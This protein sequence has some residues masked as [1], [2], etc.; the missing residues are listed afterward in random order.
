MRN[1]TGLRGKIVSGTRRVL[2]FLLA[3][4]LL[5]GT[6]GSYKLVGGSEAREIFLDGIGENAPENAEAKEAVRHALRIRLSLAESLISDPAYADA[7]G[8]AEDAEPAVR[9]E[10]FRQESAY[11]DAFGSAEDAEPA[12]RGE[13]LKPNTADVTAPDPAEESKK[14]GTEKLSGDP[15]AVLADALRKDEEQSIWQHFQEILRR[16]A[17]TAAEYERAKLAGTN[18]EENRPAD[19]GGLKGIPEDH[20]L[21][22]AESP[23]QDSPKADAEEP[24][25]ETTDNP[26]DAPEEQGF[27]ALNE[28]IRNRDSREGIFTEPETPGR[29][30]ARENPEENMPAGD[31]TYRLT[32][33]DAPYTGIFYLG[34][35]EAYARD[36]LVT[37]PAPAFPAELTFPEAAAEGDEIAIEQIS[38]AGLHMKEPT[39]AESGE[40]V[41]VLEDGKTLTFTAGAADT[42]LKLTYDAPASKEISA[43]VLWIDDPGERPARGKYAEDLF[44]TFAYGSAAPRILREENMKA[45]GI[46][47]LPAFTGREIPEGAALADL[48]ESLSE[49]SRSALLSYFKALYKEEAATRRGNDIVLCEDGQLLPMLRSQSATYHYR[50]LADYF[51]EQQPSPIGLFLVTARPLQ[52][53]ANEEERLMTHALCARLAEAAAEWLQTQHHKDNNTLRVAFGYATCPDHSLKR[54]VFDRL[55]AEQKLDVTLTDHY[56]IQPSTSVCGLFIH[57]PEAQYFPVGRIDREQLRDYC[58]RRGITIEEGEQLLSKFITHSS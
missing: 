16:E 45:L 42:S 29:K 21:A 17:G 19:E 9:S 34:D 41:T 53:S 12:V 33:N 32:I 48:L 15:W 39:F 8:S 43:L 3:L 6:V 58:Q 1:R 49:Q 37:I 20:G 46:D 40:A 27:S 10:A 50:C 5:L 54:I 24:E 23:A 7:F 51:D 47:E 18:I 55:Q 36:G 38:G 11:T 14:A 26:A 28:Q 57:H 4:A 22:G 56:S 44:I 25:S 52:E 30:F 31:F 2:A 35:A 13:A